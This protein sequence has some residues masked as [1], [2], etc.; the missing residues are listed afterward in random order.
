MDFF[1]F[2]SLDIFFLGF[3]TCIA[4]IFGIGPQNLHLIRQGIHHNYPYVTALC[5]IFADLVLFSMAIYLVGAYITEFP[6]L[7]L[8]LIFAGILFILYYTSTIIK[9]TVRIHRSTQKNST[10]TPIKLTFIPKSL[11]K[12]IG[13]TLAI[14]F[15]NPYAYLDL[16]ILLA[17]IVASYPPHQLNIFLGGIYCA[18]IVWFLALTF[19]ATKFSFLLK[20]PQIFN[21]FNIVTILVMIIILMKL[22]HD[23]I[24]LIK[25]I[26]HL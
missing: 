15:L 13:T 6:K 4:I 10:L 26:F 18:S 17:P 24:H 2:Y 3:L 20:K 9:S 19:M 14:S 5:C 8:L 23:G 25:M 16:F 21:I 1:F 22:F 11:G 12:T 7:Q